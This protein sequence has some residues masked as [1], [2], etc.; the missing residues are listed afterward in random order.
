MLMYRV[1]GNMS[2]LSHLVGG[3]REVA[4]QLGAVRWGLGEGVSL[5]VELLQ[6]GQRG[7][8]LQL[9]YLPRDVKPLLGNQRVSQVDVSEDLWSC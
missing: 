2:I 3:I 8:I 6:A 5:Q 1:Y 4:E 9:R 7:Q